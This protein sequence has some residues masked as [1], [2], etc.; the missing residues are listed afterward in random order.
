MIAKHT[1]LDAYLA[2]IAAIH[3]KLPR[4]QQLADY[5]FGHDHDATNWEAHRQSLAARDRARRVAID[6]RQPC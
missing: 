2:H 1:A 5:H 6:L 3:T 4:L